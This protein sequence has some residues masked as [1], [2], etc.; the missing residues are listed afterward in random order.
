MH[1]PLE[2]LN[3]L[4][5]LNFRHYIVNL[6]FS[7]GYFFLISTW[8]SNINSSAFLLLV[9]VCYMFFYPFTFKHHMSLC[10]VWDIIIMHRWIFFQLIWQ[11]IFC[12][13][14]S[15]YNFHGCIG[16]WMFIPFKFYFHF[17]CSFYVVVLFIFSFLLFWN[18]WFLK[19]FYFLLV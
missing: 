16:I 18:N 5:Q 10:L 7:N 3:I 8:I 1:T 4:A 17:C 2:L 12:T 9:F 6:F 13:M 15:I 19:K 14:Q 11:S